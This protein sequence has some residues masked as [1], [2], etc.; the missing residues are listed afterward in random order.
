MPRTKKKSPSPTLFQEEAFVQLIIEGLEEDF[1]FQIPS[2]GDLRDITFDLQNP[3]T[4]AK[5]ASKKKKPLAEVDLEFPPC[6]E[7]DLL[8]WKSVFPSSV[9]KPYWISGYQVWDPEAPVR[10]AK[11]DK[12]K[13]QEPLP[14]Q[15]GLIRHHQYDSRVL[16]VPRTQ[17]RKACPL[18][19]PGEDREPSWEFNE[20]F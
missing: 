17:I 15:I 8:R 11:G 16:W 13:R 4:E 20:V 18:P 14:G 19:P 10:H 2:S 3:E 6:T 7:V 5:K 1:L 9:R 12:R